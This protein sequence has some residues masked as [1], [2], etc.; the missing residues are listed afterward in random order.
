[1]F[2][3]YFPYISNYQEK[4]KYNLLYLA[5]GPYDSAI[6][7]AHMGSPLEKG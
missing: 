7:G 3:I 1:M 6:I 2:Q 5:I 4:K